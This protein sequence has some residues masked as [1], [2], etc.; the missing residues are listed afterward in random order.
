LLGKE[1]RQ[2]SFFDTDFACS[3]LI[4]KKSFYAKMHDLSDKIITDDDFADIYCLNNGRPSVPPARITKVLIL[5]TYEDLSDREALEMV[6][7]NIKWKYALD[8]PI[9]YEGFDRSL[10]V[11]FR[12]RLLINDKEKMVFKK[13]LELAREAGLLKEEVDQVID[14]TPMLG[15]GAVKDTYGTGE[16]KPKINWDNRKERGKLL[17]LLVS[18]ARKVLSGVDITEEEGEGTDS[19]LQGAARLLSRIVSQDMEED[20]DKKPKIK[21]GVAKD[22]IISTTDPEMRHGRKSRSGKF[23]GYKTHLTKDVSSEIITNIDVS[24]ANSPD[25]E[26]AELLIDEAKEEFGVKTKSLTGDGAYGSSDIEKKMSEK[27]IE[28]ISKVPTSKN[29]GK[30]SKE[31]FEIDLEN[32]KVTC[33]KGNTTDKYYLSKDAKGQTTKTFV[34]PQKVCQLCSRRNE[35]TEAKDT[36]RTIRVGPNEEYLQMMRARQKTKEFKE[37]Y[38]KRRPPIERKI[39]E[40]IY[41]GLRKTKYIGRRKSR[42]QALFTASV[43]NLKRV[44]KHRE[45]EKITFDIPEAIPLLT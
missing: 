40:L 2:T 17:S 28:L 20:E 1:E 29:Q 33:P 30:L 36:G 34:F 5:E 10:L 27:E 15:A 24:P 6:R 16:P 11:H 38:N 31:E 13:T 7:F 14:S 45:D 19:E 8:V 21:R 43:V 18:D 35:C 4:D 25:Q 12:A 22:R 32:E 41:H 23:N 39:A 26:M 44:L 42:L 37:I 9:D 3:H